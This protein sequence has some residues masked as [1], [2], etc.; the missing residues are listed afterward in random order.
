M[1]AARFPEK[2]NSLVLAGA[3]IH[4]DA[5]DGPIKRMVHASPM[6]FYEELVTLGGGL[7]RGKLM[8]QGWKNM[9]PEQQYFQ[10]HIDLYEH[11]DDPA[12]LKKKKRSRAGT[13]T[14][15][16]CRGAGTTKEQN[17]KATGSWRPHWLVYGIA[18]SDA[19]V[20]GYCAMDWLSDSR[21]KGRA[22]RINF[23][24]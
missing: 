8:L 5:G 18:R 1:I 15:S 23:W 22:V 13:K 10:D 20:A 17:R 6:A 24:R 4:T 21:V 19:G 11:I 9:H 3:P 2:V 12:Y 14:R 7:M 16:I